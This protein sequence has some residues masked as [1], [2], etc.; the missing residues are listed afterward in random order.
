MSRSYS[1]SL[2]SQSKL[3]DGP[4]KLKL[5]KIWAKSLEMLQVL[6]TFCYIERFIFPGVMKQTSQ[7]LPFVV[8]NFGSKATMTLY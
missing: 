8:T 3:V 6:K 5:S 1:V 2:M 7:L 4:M